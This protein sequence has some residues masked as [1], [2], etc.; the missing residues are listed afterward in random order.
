MDA[1]FV[2]TLY[3]KPRRERHQQYRCV[4]YW[5]GQLQTAEAALGDAN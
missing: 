4:N 1:Q 3:F 2:Q 5:L